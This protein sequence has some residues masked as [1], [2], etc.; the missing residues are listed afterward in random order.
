MAGHTLDLFGVDGY[1]STAVETRAP[2]DWFG[3]DWWA[4]DIES[5]LRRRPRF[6]ATGGR[7]QKRHVLNEYFF[8][9]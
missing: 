7:A 2:D 3:V 6:L 4:D 8:A 9:D 5:N 1:P